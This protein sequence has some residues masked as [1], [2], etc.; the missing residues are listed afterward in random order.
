MRIP[1]LVFVRYSYI[2]SINP[3]YRQLLIIILLV[4]R[5][6][7]LEAQVY[8]NITTSDG[9]NNNNIYS[10]ARDK[11]GFM[12]FLSSG[13][14]DRFDGLD[15][16]HF[17]LSISN[18]PIGFCSDFHLVTDKNGDIWQ[19]GSMEGHSICHYNE[20]EGR[21]DYIPMSGLKNKGISFLF[22]DKHNRI[23]MSN[24]N[25]L[26]LYDIE[27]R[28]KINLPVTLISS[29]TCGAEV[30]DDL[31]VIGTQRGLLVIKKEEGK[32]NVRRFDCIVNWKEQEIK[33]D[34][35]VVG[36]PLK[37]RDVFV[38]SVAVN[39]LTDEIFVFDVKSRYYKI[40]LYDETV[41]AYISS[42]IYDTPITD[43]QHLS[44]SSDNLLIATE[45]RG[46]FTFDMSKCTVSQFLRFGA[47]EELGLRGYVVMSI[48]P[49]LDNQRIWFANYPYGIC[50]YN[51]AFPRYKHYMHI[52]DNP[53]S[54]S[55]G[56]VRT[57]IE[58]S[59][60]DI[61]YVTSGGICCNN[62]KTGEWRHYLTGHKFGNPIFLS[63]CEIRPGLIMVAGLMSGSIVV[64]KASGNYTII[65]PKYFG[66]EVNSMHG[67]RGI[68]KDINGVLWIGGEDRL[69]RIDWDNKDYKSYPLNSSSV[70]LAHKDDGHF[71]HATLDGLYVVDISDGS[72]T[73]FPLSVNCIDINAVLTAQNGDLYIGTA[74]AGLFVLQSGKKEIPM[75]FDNYISINSA[76]ISNNIL[77]LVEDSGRT[78]IMSTD[79]G[80]SRFYPEKKSF[81][82]WMPSQGMLDNGFYK[83]SILYTSEN[84]ILF[85]T[86]D[87][88]IEISDSIRMP[89]VLNSKIIFSNLYIG[90][91]KRNAS[92][93]FSNLDLDY[94]ER[95]ISF[96]IS[97]LNY[98]NP[99][100]FLYSWCL[101]GS[102]ETWTTLS[103]NRQ[104]RYLLN[105][106]KYRLLVR[107][108]NSADYSLSEERVVTIRVS[109][110]WWSSLPAKIIYIFLLFAVVYAVYLFFIYRNKRIM[111]EDKV[112]FF[113][114]TAH[115]IRT[116]LTLVKAPLEEISRN[117]N[118]SEK[119]RKNMQ[120]V[121][122]SANDLLILTSDLLNIERLKMRSTE[123][124][125]SE[126][127]VNSYMQEL[128]I[129]FQLY[130]K[131]KKLNLTY[132]SSSLNMQVW[133]DRSRMDSIMQNVINNALKYTPEGG[134]IE[135]CC[136]S[137]ERDWSVSVADNG[138]GIPEEEQSKLSEMYFRSSNAD[139]QAA[140][141]GVGLHLV[142]RLVQEHKGNISFVSEE[143]KGTT[144]TLTFP[145][146]ISGPQ[147]QESVKVR[148]AP[149]S[150]P[151]VLVVEDNKDLRT[152]IGD[153][154]SENY[155]VHTAVN[156]QE[157][158]DKVRFLNPDIIVSD[159]MMPKM[160]GDELCRRLK[161]EV[162]TSHIPVILL[163]ALADR[164][165]VVSGLSTMADAYLTKPFNTTV[166]KAQ[167]DSIIA[168]RKNLRKLYAH[169][170]ENA[171]NAETP[172]VPAGNDGDVGEQHPAVQ[173]NEL[174]MAFMKNV[175]AIIAKEMGNCNFNVDMLCT[176]VCMSRT[177]LYNKVKS[178]T[179]YAPAD[180]IR[181]RRLEHSKM[182]LL[183]SQLT[184]TEI[185]D[186]C[187]FNDPKYFR[188]VFR[189]NYGAS[190]SQFRHDRKSSEAEA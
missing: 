129:P 64:E 160:R 132:S 153:V 157:A 37:M 8:Q 5:C 4:V 125:V 107:A 130:A 35:T 124:E 148:K 36:V 60:G 67:V 2:L 102:G 54:L 119:G 138:I 65:S 19:V 180:F 127:D 123:L 89:H 143:G 188:E 33:N 156:G 77:S 52:K 6:S 25:C 177:S 149:L 74:D 20:K 14:I 114:Q 135:V 13:G 41:E 31:Y 120:M 88:V 97:N 17:P 10:I 110:P 93:D 175:N 115:E 168:N 152:F 39:K 71:W 174:D 101:E 184:V 150:A 81:S 49:D 190:P 15:F 172:V 26:F 56:I 12:W 76:L 83:S 104:I 151:V 28:K 23:W 185:A 146:N 32:W 145:I 165:S 43:I 109:P 84:N 85:G 164:D 167:I 178:L 57:M 9:L 113:I 3:M 181:F 80:I 98:E 59:D 30:K 133:M 1:L 122:K 75:N 82:T 27:K 108:Y 86:Y 106:G 42:S 70:L 144:F 29:I 79:Q 11:D 128:M 179:G 16:I 48:F 173:P 69:V 139:K 40:N 117:E 55:P 91:T 7:L 176:E 131:T 121:M 111:A 99:N 50:R 170:G 46:V 155:T 92:F 162:E 38:K 116:P 44:E 62:P 18:R 58:D 154:L 187:G 134:S 140:G 90:G 163:T 68:Y 186:K 34:V 94:D 45:G 189:K 112:N 72:R 161:S 136:R 169:V 87:G 21:F 96:V 147:K 159:V 24:K 171:E 61:W 51:M 141:S 95:Q 182:L 78:I 137:M 53:Q 47:E 183:S 100:A 142:Q 63:V 22:L 66:F 118:L 126:V 105:P 73:K 103:H 158:Y 166:L